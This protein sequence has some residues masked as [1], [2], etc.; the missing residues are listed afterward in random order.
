MLREHYTD[1]T[2]FFCEEDLTSAEFS[3]DSEAFSDKQRMGNPIF[4]AIGY[5]SKIFYENI[6]KYIIGYTKKDG[7]VLDSCAGSGSTGLAAL[8]EGRKAIL[9]DNSPLATNMQYNL[10]NYVDLQELDKIFRKCLAELSPLIDDIY[11]T[12]MSDGRDGVA[13]VIIASNIY[14]CP[15][16]GE[17]ICLYKNDTGTRSEYKCTQ[18]G[19]IINIA[20][21][22]IK[23]LQVDKRRPVEV[24]VRPVAGVGK[25]ETRPIS[26][27]DKQTWEMKYNKYNAVYGDLWAPSTKIV[28]N[29]SYPRIG[30]W[31]GFS[32]DASVSDLFPKPNLL[33]L[34][35]L[36][37]Y[38]E[39]QITD[40]DIQSF[41]KF[42]FTETLFRT[43]SR[44]FTG[45]GIKNVYHIPPVGKE[46]NVLTVFNR[47]YNDITKAKRFLQEQ[48]DL[49][50]N[51][52]R[53]KIINTDS[54]ALPLP[55]NS[56][57]YVFIDPPYGG[58]VPYAELNL[59]YSSWL[60]ENEDLDGEII[61]PMDYE[62]KDGYVEK[63]GAYIESAFGE[64]V[65]VL[66]P[67]GHFT[68]AFH[69]TFSN[70]WNELKDIMT[71]R[72]G[73]EFVN[74]VENER[75]T[76]FHT[77]Q[78]NDTNP[79]TAFITYRKPKTGEVADLKIKVG[80]VFIGIPLDFWENGKTFRE[81][82]SEIIFMVNKQNYAEVP[83]EKE[84]QKWLSMNCK[85]EGDK[86]YLK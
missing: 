42:I 66:R 6:Q 33:A 36:N 46:Q 10:L 31:P 74:I 86:Y 34:K 52:D 48:V 12:K 49:Q 23:D 7:I 61:I 11:Y 84:I 16:C 20:K 30:G 62:K 14:S 65:R 77:N 21:Q 24:T 78:I 15:S 35:I 28:Y 76:T 50:Q 82:Q 45:S 85:L 83:S 37:N 44:L 57:D 19:C 32:I 56:V 64:A 40:L 9:I 2:K 47:K 70:I 69:S 51:A 25:R 26:E 17:E 73:L 71:R 5:P 38:I 13:D 63:W 68:V 29:R 80:S 67:G 75:G 60:H 54:K 27:D 39:T 41:M 55:N 43:S 22:S 1:L 8:L 18:C 59:F 81:V 3:F 72:L 79:V 53:V 58:M 4:K